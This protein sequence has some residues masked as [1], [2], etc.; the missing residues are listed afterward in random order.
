VK[1]AG[2]TDISSAEEKLDQL[3]QSGGNLKDANLPHFYQMSPWPCAPSLESSLIQGSGT[4]S[5]AVPFKP[6]VVSFKD[7]A[8]SDAAVDR[9]EWWLRRQALAY[10]L[11]ICP[12]FALVSPEM[13]EEK[14]AELI[15]SSAEWNEFTVEQ[16]REVG[17]QVVCQSLQMSEKTGEVHSTLQVE[18]FDSARDDLLA[19]F[20]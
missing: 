7:F 6:V 5:N 13:S 10:T 18:G 9:A 12:I 4:F 17:K 14:M 11:G 16:L 20:S 2:S 8:V 3:A 15:A 19:R 1:A